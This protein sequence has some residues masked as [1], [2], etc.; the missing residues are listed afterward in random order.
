[1]PAAYQWKPSD[2]IEHMRKVHNARVGAIVDLT[3]SGKYYQPEA[4]ETMQVRHI[5]I[6][7]KGHGEVPTPAEVNRFVW[8]VHLEMAR[9]AT[10]W[11]AV[12]DCPNA[13]RKSAQETRVQQAQACVCPGEEG[14]GKVR[15]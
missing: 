4:F 12:R 13:A 14:A 11:E 3:Y 7:C 8:E 2:V 1:V 6:P 10:Q 9:L 15:R 5:K